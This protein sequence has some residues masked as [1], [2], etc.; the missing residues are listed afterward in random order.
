ML[1]IKAFEKLGIRRLCLRCSGVNAPFPIRML[2][3]VVLGMVYYFFI[4]VTISPI[5][6]LTFTLTSKIEQEAK[7]HIQVE[8]KLAKLSCN[9]TSVLLDNSKKHDYFYR[10]QEEV[11]ISLNRGRNECQSYHI[12]PK[13]KQKIDFLDFT[14]LFTLWGI[15]LYQLLFFIFMWG[16]DRLK[17][18]NRSGIGGLCP[19]SSGVNAPFPKQSILIWLIGVILF[20]GVVIRIVYFQKYGIM[21]FQHD[22]HGHIEFIEYI[23]QNWNLPS[24]PMKSLEFPQ[25]P[26]Y[27]LITGGLYSLLIE[28]GFNHDDALY[29]IGYFSLF[30]SMIFLLYSYRLI[31]V[32]THNQWVQLVAIVFISL[33]PSVV[34]LSA[35]INNDSLVMALSVVS[36]YYI[37]KSYQTA[38]QK[39]F[40]LAL[41]SVSLL[42]L[43]KVSASSIELLLFALLLVAYY[44]SDKRK[45]NLLKK[46]L[47]WYGLVG[48]FLLTFTLFRVYMPLEEGAFYLVNSAKYPKQT[49]ELLDFNYFTSFN[50]IDLITTG[51]CHIFGEDSIRHS[52]LTYQ[53]G[54]M[55]FGESNY[56]Y[57]IHKHPALFVLM[58]SILLLGLIYLIGFIAYLINLRHEPL[59]HKILFGVLFINFILIIKF[60]LMYPSICNT[61]FRYFVAS[62]ILQ[63]FVFARGLEYITSILTLQWM[64][65]IILIGLVISEI[66]F[67]YGLLV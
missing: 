53:Y 46:S 1:N 30:C 57:F 3:L 44:K 49:I 8:H 17:Q 60:L 41:L 13:I 27:Y 47:Y 62:F 22:W 59:L 32:L 12:M 20:L 63:G 25:Q 54:T 50:I 39:G 43:T 5:Q 11:I 31:R 35:R 6:N 9:G 29:C 15:P 55:F 16:M 56:A 23:A 28:V 38:F 24:I 45:E 61:D 10:G 7:F 33:T 64:V 2:F 67:F 58:Q 42:F 66:L 26:L 36:I 18:K 40:Y 4:I 34:Y 14:V 52:F 37:I 51:Q 65:N 19:R 48:I 21:V